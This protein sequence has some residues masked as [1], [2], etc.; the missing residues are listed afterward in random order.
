MN[1]RNKLKK[2]LMEDV[3]IAPNAAERYISLLLRENI[4]SSAR[5][6]K[7]LQRNMQWL[8]EHDVDS[9]DEEDIKQNLFP[10]LEQD[11]PGSSMMTGMATKLE[12]EC[13]ELKKT[14]EILQSELE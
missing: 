3:E 12:N 6:K 9:F 2:W 8:R 10:E 7:V 11:R 4:A 1:M 5:L 14:I 13:M